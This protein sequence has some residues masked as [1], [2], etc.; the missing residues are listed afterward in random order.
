MF[1]QPDLT[2]YLKTWEIIS[3]GYQTHSIYTHFWPLSKAWII[4]WI[5][6]T[7]F[8]ML[9]NGWPRT[10]AIGAG[11]S[12]SSTNER[13]VFCHRPRLANYILSDCAVEAHI[14]WFSDLSVPCH[15][16]RSKATALTGRTRSG[17]VFTAVLLV[18]RS[19][20]ITDIL[21][22]THCDLAYF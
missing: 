6:H 9:L 1:S 19:V 4:N 8:R 16:V 18:F 14:P 13:A 5:N 15:T 17:L 22:S 7:T 2:C 10:C 3:E 11:G 20:L 12:T 21:L